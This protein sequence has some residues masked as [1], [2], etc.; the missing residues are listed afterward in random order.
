MY[1]DVKTKHIAYFLNDVWVMNVQSKTA[2]GL[3][4]SKNLPAEESPFFLYV[5]KQ[6]KQ[7]FASTQLFIGRT[8]G[9]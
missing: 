9:V 3:I 2:C 4:Y 7:I 5:T 6:F 1:L 8:D